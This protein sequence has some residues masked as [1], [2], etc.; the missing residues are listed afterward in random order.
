[1]YDTPYDVQTKRL[2]VALLV[3]HRH[4]IP[5]CFRGFLLSG[6]YAYE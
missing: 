2:A 6:G 1:M 4:T 3:E 5:V